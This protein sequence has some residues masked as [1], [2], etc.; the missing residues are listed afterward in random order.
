MECFS[1][2]S[3]KSSK[4]DGELKESEHYCYFCIKNHG[5]DRIAELNWESVR[6]EIIQEQAEENMYLQSNE[7]DDSEGEEMEDETELA[8]EENS[9]SRPR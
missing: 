7:L 1:L 5:A 8:G 4:I 9:R 2:R 6:E 3:S